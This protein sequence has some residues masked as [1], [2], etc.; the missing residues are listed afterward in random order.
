MQEIVSVD[1]E[2]ATESNKNPCH[3]QL[4]CRLNLPYSKG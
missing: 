2:M 3:Q 4:H 1:P